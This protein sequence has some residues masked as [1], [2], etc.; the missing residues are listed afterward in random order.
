MQ[1]ASICFSLV[2]VVGQWEHLFAF[3]EAIHSLQHSARLMTHISRISIFI[4]WS[5]SASLQRSQRRAGGETQRHGVRVRSALAFGV[6]GEELPSK[7]V[8]IYEVN[9]SV[10]ISTLIRLLV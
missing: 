6:L 7:V 10:L 1:S 5:M 8:S 3:P 9:Q 4:V 2:K